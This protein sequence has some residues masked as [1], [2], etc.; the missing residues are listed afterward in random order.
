[1]V[2]GDTDHGLKIPLDYSTSLQKYFNV[3]LAIGNQP[4]D[5]VTALKATRNNL[6]RTANELGDLL[7]LNDFKKQ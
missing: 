7:F 5:L 4:T 3:L 6:I 2:G 1:V